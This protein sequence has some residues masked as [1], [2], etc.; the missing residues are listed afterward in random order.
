MSHLPNSRLAA[1]SRLAMKRACRKEGI[2]TPA[3]V[4]ASRESDVER[5]AKKLRFP[6]FVKH[7]NSYASVALSRISRVRTPAGL[8]RQARKIISRFG[9]ALIEEYIDGTECTVLVAEN[10]DD[11]ARP[12]TYTPMQ[13]RF[14]EGE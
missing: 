8:R 9:K 3:Y 4:F 6:L 1:T 11:P 5:A 10:A 2:D 12:K 13:Y 14:P 7:H